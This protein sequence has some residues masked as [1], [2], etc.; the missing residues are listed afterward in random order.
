MS[1]DW[2]LYEVLQNHGYN[3][4][5]VNHSKNIG[6]IHKQNELYHSDNRMYL[7]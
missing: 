3:Y 1:D 4:L 7:S 5:T 6:V 2:K